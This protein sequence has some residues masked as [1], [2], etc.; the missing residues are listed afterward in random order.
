MDKYFIRSI[1]KFNSQ[2][3]LHF[4][5]TTYPPEKDLSAQLYILTTLSL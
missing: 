4:T 5:Q 1:S 2:I 3:S